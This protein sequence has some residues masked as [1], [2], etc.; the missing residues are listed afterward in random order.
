MQADSNASNPP[1]RPETPLTQSP[2]RS[3]TYYLETVT[4]QVED[5]LF[6]VPKVQFMRGSSIFR[7]MFSLPQSENGEGYAEGSSDL[8]PLK[9]EGVE[10]VDFERLLKVMYP[11]DVRAEWSHQPNDTW[12]SVL[13]LSKMWNFYEL[14]SMAVETLT[15]A[16]MDP[17]DRIIVAKTY[18]IPQ[19]LRTGYNQL[20]T[21]EN[22]LTPEEGAKVEMTT[23]MTIAQAREDFL[24]HQTGRYSTSFD[25]TYPD[26][27]TVPIS[28]EKLFGQEL[29][30]ADLEHSYFMAGE[31]GE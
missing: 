9:L 8:N 21:R 3:E 14:H 27:Y 31:F 12:V 10:K 15:T 4:F 18:K 22:P 2:Q 11:H 23:A 24:R 19:W 6:K 1:S 28:L 26:G 29:T 7:A 20:I 5:T 13:K 17:L 30:V 25:T 16:T